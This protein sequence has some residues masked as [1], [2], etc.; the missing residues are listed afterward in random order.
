MTDVSN[1]KVREGMTKTTSEL[2]IKVIS[3][4]IRTLRDRNGNGRGMIGVFRHTLGRRIPANG[5]ECQIRK[6]RGL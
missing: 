3:S 6:V 1:V 4:G 5:D 2:P